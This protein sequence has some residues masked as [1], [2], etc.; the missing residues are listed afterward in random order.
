MP[1]FFVAPFFAALFF[2][3]MTT[4]AFLTAAFLIATGRFVI[5]FLDELFARDCVREVAGALRAFR[6]ASRRVG[7]FIVPVYF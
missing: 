6:R 5:T 7:F 1:L 4:R 2:A 3:L